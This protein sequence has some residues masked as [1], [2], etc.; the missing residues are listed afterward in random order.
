VVELVKSDAVKKLKP[1]RCREWA[2]QFSIENMV[3]RYEDLCKEAIEG[4]W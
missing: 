1:E 4:G 3:K 2:S